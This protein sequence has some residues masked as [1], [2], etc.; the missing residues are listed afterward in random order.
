MANIIDKARGV[1]K[2]WK[3]QNP[4]MPENK[5]KYWMDVLDDMVDYAT[6]LEEKCYQRLE[7]KSNEEKI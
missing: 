6:F 2:E 5:E 7:K 4:L 1:V 3:K